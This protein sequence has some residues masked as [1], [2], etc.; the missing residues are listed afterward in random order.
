[1]GWRGSEEGTEWIR[2]KSPPC[3]ISKHRQQQMLSSTS[4]SHAEKQRKALRKM[5]ESA[6]LPRPL[7]GKKTPHQPNPKSPPAAQK[8]SNPAEPPVPHLSASRSGIRN[9]RF[10]HVMSRPMAVPDHRH[11]VH[12]GLRCVWAATSPL[13][14][15]RGSSR[16]GPHTYLPLLWEP[17]ILRHCKEINRTEGLTAVSKQWAFGRWDIALGQEETRPLGQEETP[18][19]DR[20]GQ[21]Q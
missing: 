2:L 12:Q 15:T 13:A 20:T 7:K 18:A 8:N 10:Q 3:P 17:C 6:W 9:S 21:G 1:M 14:C 11:W 5:R 19:Q 16:E 4:V